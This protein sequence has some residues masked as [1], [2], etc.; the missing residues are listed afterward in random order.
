LLQ[1]KSGLW[2]VL[3]EENVFQNVYDEGLSH[4]G[5]LF[6]NAMNQEEGNTNVNG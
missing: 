1:K 3:S 2:V 5:D 4:V 6:S